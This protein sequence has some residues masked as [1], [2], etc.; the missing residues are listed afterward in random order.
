MT[1]EEKLEL[2]LQ[3]IVEA[4]KFARKGYFTTLYYTRDNG[5]ININLNE[6]H[7]ILLKLEDEEKILKVKALPNELETVYDI[8]KKEYFLIDVP[9]EFTLWYEAHI[10]E[11]IHNIENIDWVNLLKVYDV[12]LDINQQLQLASSKEVYI[13]ALPQMVKFPQLF[14]QDDIGTRRTYQGYRM[15]GVDFLNKR[16]GVVEYK[17]IDTMDGGY[18]EIK[19]VVNLLEFRE[20]FLKIGSE[21]V[22]RLEMLKKTQ[23]EPKEEKPIK[24]M[25]DNPP[26]E[27]KKIDT[28]YEIFYTKQRQVLLNNLEIA[29][30][31]FDSENELAFSFLIDNPNKKH[32]KADVEKAIGKSLTKT[33]HKIVENLG[34]TGDIR[35]AFFDV[36]KDS[37]CFKNPI[38]QEDLDKLGIV[39]LKLPK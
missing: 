25:A 12:A 31:D 27:G 34:F 39:K 33:L 10:F 11:N 26:Q 28:V 9:P 36:S 4:K 7:D 18:G 22:R 19:V 37:I 2:I 5:L 13:P 30:P 35:K 8:Q 23:K 32:T 3:A 29:K 1:Y 17:Y 21:Y 14:P 38:K 15:E 16:G 24:K 20:F 6:I